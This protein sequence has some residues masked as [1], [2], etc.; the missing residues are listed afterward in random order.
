MKK[1]I[2]RT[3]LGLMLLLLSLPA[4]FSCTHIGLVA[5]VR[6]ADVF[7]P[8]HIQANVVSGVLLGSP[9]IKNIV[10]RDVDIPIKFKL[11]E[12]KIE[13]HISHVF[14]FVINIPAIKLTGA[15][16][17]LTDNAT[18]RISQ[19]LLSGKI[20]SKSKTALQ[21]QWENALIPIKEGLVLSVPSAQLALT[22]SLFDYHV[23][24][25][26]TT[27][28]ADYL[29]ANWQL[30]DTTGTM[31][32][33][34]I[35]SLISTSSVGNVTLKGQ[36]DW[37]NDLKWD[38]YL[39]A[40]KL[41][42]AVFKPEFKSDLQLKLHTQGNM[43]ATQPEYKA[44]LQTLSG[45]F[46]GLP[47]HGAGQALIRAN[48]Y[49]FNH[50]TL[51]I[52]SANLQINGG[53]TSAKTNLDWQLV[54][55]SLAKLSPNVKGSINSHGKLSGN[56]KNPHIAGNLA[57]S[58]VE[59][60]TL[61]L[62]SLNAVFDMHMNL[63]DPSELHLSFSQLTTGTTELTTGQVNFNNQ[64]R[65]N[66]LH[67]ALTAPDVVVVFDSSGHL[68]NK[69]W[70]GKIN[71]LSVKAKDFG[72]I[73]LK[74][75]VKLTLARHS[76]NL[77]PFC[78]QGTLGGICIQRADFAVD[79]ST[80]ATTSARPMS[81]GLQLTSQ[82]LA[83]IN[84]F[85]PQL[86][87]VGG[88]LSINFHLGG[89]TAKPLVSGRATL[90]NGAF[91]I[92]SLGVKI[93]EVSLSATANNDNVGYVA[94]AKLGTNILTITGKTDLAN[95]GFPTHVA[96][97]G[98]E[99]LVMN[100]A[101]AV[102]KA[103]PD[104]QLDWINS[105]LSITG[106]VDIPFA[107]ITPRDITTTITLPGDVVWVTA[108]KQEAKQPLQIYSHLKVNFGDN[109][110]F[111]YAGLSGKVK[112]SLRVEDK[113]GGDTVGSGTL[114][115][116]DGKYKAYGQD[117]TIR[118][119]KM[120]YTGGPINNPGLNIEAVKSLQLVSSSSSTGSKSMGSGY[121]S[122]KQTVGIRLTGTL[123]APM[124]RLFAEPAGLSQSDILSYLVLGRP[125]SQSTQAD[126][127][128]IMQALSLL[129]VGGGVTNQLK[130]QFASA[131]GLSQLSISKEQEYDQQQNTVVENTSL[132]LGKSLSPRLLVSYSLGLVEPINT[133]K[134]VY[135]LRKNISLQSEHSSEGN[136]VDLFY[137]YERN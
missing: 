21:L 106:S 8:G 116:E 114:I 56:I 124:A 71:E 128:S 77:Q 29:Q 130:N 94:N 9:D 117:L 22:N 38:I 96:I 36:I 129:N 127:P 26:F 13:W 64:K 31:H 34:D 10:Y 84:G 4:F 2:L 7:V 52:G 5:L 45:V 113:P 23:Q 98:H 51:G 15:E 17:T 59:W 42:A 46:E 81:G 112:G 101:N 123:M 49:E 50:L 99:L 103:S 40:K 135:K 54:V 125:A 90:A 108:E 68:L 80:T 3:L 107:N 78:I 69:Q 19:L 137:T 120:I 20:E 73:G 53:V 1:V 43:S 57:L 119:G 27:E 70:Q 110:Q 39:D 105:L 48:D 24:G 111:N 104:L 132:L 76:F 74:Q 133:L 66:Q 95:T 82:D 118:Q 33:I 122:S 121:T 58:H 11:D 131:F 93:E 47:I 88:K 62:A 87:H 79:N 14:P 85:L 115:I 136:G 97:K 6:L 12:L 91:D 61:T 102:V 75:P 37:F 60:N 25:H 41:N 16:V 55:P 63:N 86:S 134:V 67:I 92:P 126:S 32:S 44:D 18:Y 30:A 89:T 35:G 83:F 28:G 109:I 100:T 72:E 65:Q